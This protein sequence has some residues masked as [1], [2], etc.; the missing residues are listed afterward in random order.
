MRFTPSDVPISGQWT[1]A[2]YLNGWRN[3]SND[4][5]PVQYKVNG[6]GSIELRG[7]CKGGDATPWK[8]AFKI[9][10]PVK[11]EK[12][13]FIRAMTKDYQ[14]CTLNV[15]ESGIVVVV[16]DVNSDWLCLDGITIT[17]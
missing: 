13:M 5:Y 6:N 9:T 10:F 17:N 4:Y 14:Q 15:Y 16:K 7:S 12:S 2:T 3:Y 11:P 8:H 1:N